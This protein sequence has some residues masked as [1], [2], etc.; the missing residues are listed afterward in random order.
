MQPEGFIVT[1]AFPARAPGRTPKSRR[2]RAGRPCHEGRA[3]TPPAK[4]EDEDDLVAAE[5]RATGLQAS[6]QLLRYLRPL[7]FRR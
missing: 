5:P 7:C 2:L 3:R 4:I 6:L 1:W